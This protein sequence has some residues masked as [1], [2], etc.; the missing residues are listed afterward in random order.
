MEITIEPVK[1][2]VGYNVLWGHS[3]EKLYHSYMTFDKD[4]RVGALVDGQSYDVRVDSFNE[5]GI[6]TG[7]VTFVE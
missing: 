7:K 1:D 2:A 4:L 3:R 5:S 6:T